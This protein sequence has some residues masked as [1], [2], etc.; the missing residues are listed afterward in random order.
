MRGMIGHHSSFDPYETEVRCD[1]R[2]GSK[3]H[4]VKAPSVN[5]Q[6]TVC[7]G[8]RSASKPDCIREGREPLHCERVGPIM[9]VA[10]KI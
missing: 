10:K 7:V 3:L 9:E 5:T 4:I 1:I 6:L 8:G 2:Y